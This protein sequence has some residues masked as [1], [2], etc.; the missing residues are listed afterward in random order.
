MRAALL[1]IAVLGLSCRRE[2]AR[3]SALESNLQR[4]VE[5][6]NAMIADAQS[7]GGRIIRFDHILVVVRQRLIQGVL[8]AGLPVERTLGGRFRVRV[9]KAEVL[10]E[11]GFATVRL[12]GQAHLADRQDV[13]ADISVHGAID[14]VD[15]D[16]QS[17][18]L[19]GRVKVYAMEARKVEV[20]GF[21]APIA[22]LVEDLGRER[23]ETFEALLTS[24][25]IPVRVGRE[26]LLP[27][28]GPEGGITIQET[29][30]PVH[31]VVESVKSF[32]HRLWVTITTGVDAEPAAAAR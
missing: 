12:D 30:V 6:L 8:D 7:N 4:R 27:R 5:G 18:I 9:G 20:A 32:R 24:L 15:L 13:R 25:E 16:P 10:L 11:D 21:E 23:L 26:I 19:R 29:A 3:L 28:M 17:G 14:I 1:L 31:A 22:Q 2:P